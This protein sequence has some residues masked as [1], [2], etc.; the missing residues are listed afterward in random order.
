LLAEVVVADSLVVA[1]VL[2]VTEPRLVLQAAAVLP[3]L[4]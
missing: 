1:A 4:L 3:S 2:V